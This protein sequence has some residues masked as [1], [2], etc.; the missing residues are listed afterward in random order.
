MAVVAT[1]AAATAAAAPDAIE[2]ETVDPAPR[3]KLC[4]LWMP[5]RP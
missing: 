1:V 4:R 2:A 3:P 5:F